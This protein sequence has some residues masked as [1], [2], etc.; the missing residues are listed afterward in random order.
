MA[1][2]PLRERAGLAERIVVRR[3][4]SLCAQEP[5]YAHGREDNRNRRSRASGVRN[6]LEGGVPNPQPRSARTKTDRR[7]ALAHR[8]Q[9]LGEKAARPRA[10]IGERDLQAPRR[11]SRHRNVPRPK[12]ARDVEGASAAPDNRST[13]GSY[14]IQK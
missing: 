12:S 11:A 8:I 5:V 9:R 3:P 6:R 2:A 13:L 14:M 4:K 7:A 1:A 10:R